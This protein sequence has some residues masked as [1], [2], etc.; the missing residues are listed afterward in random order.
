[1]IYRYNGASARYVRAN[2]SPRPD[3]EPVRRAASCT[4]HKREPSMPSSAQR[5]ASTTF[6]DRDAAFGRG[7][8]APLQLF[9]VSVGI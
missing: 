3:G 5:I 6:H 2:G 8:C 7:R 1:V 9:L 4:R